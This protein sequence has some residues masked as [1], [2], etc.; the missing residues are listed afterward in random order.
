MKVLVIDDEPQVCEVIA[1]SLGLRWPDTVVVSAGTGKA[2]IEMAR[3][4]SPDL[5]I[6]LPDRDG[7]EVCQ[8]LSKFATAPMLMLTVRNDQLDTVKGLELGADDYITK[9]FSQLEMLA[10]VQAVLRRH[11]S[12]HVGASEPPYRRGRILIDFDA[13]EVKIDGVEVNL[14]PIEYSI[15]YYLVKDADRVV[16]HKALVEKVW[17]RNIWIRLII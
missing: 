3:R 9:P 11:H 13:R 10:R 15:L 16:P 7:F 4:E 1:I 5:D 8:E 6:G 17:G 2:G 14:P 12:P